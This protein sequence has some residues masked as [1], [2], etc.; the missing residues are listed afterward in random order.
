[1][2]RQK[3]PGKDNRDKIASRNLKAYE[4]HAGGNRNFRLA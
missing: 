3:R 2:I 4:T 1:M